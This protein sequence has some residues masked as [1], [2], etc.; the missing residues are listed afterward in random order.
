MAETYC[1]GEPLSDGEAGVLRAYVR[2]DREYLSANDWTGAM[3]VAVECLVARGY[4][5][6]HERG[7]LVTPEGVAAA[8]N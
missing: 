7:M 8:L 3:R 4:L 2:G 5:Q 1:V 6:R